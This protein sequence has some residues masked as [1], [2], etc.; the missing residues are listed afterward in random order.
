M[1]ASDFDAGSD[2]EALKAAMKGLGTDEQTIIDILAH[3]SIEQRLEIAENYKT[4]Y[5]EVCR[6][7]YTFIIYYN[8]YT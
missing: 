4:M 3:R 1:P 7:S 6:P 8:K 5:G 2:C